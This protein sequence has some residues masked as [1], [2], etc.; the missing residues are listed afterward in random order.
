MDRFNNL[1]MSLMLVTVLA[2]YMWASNEDYKDY[3]KNKIHYFEM[4]NDGY[5]NYK[6]LDC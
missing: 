6:K 1:K 5:P 4:V 3:M 2:I